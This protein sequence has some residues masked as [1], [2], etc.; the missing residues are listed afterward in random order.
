LAQGS[1]GTAR[2]APAARR[3]CRGGPMRLTVATFIAVGALPTAPPRESMQMQPS[4]GCAS[5]FHT[6]APVLFPLVPAVLPRT[7]GL[8]HQ[9]YDQPACC[10]PAYTL[11]VQA[12]VEGALQ[13]TAQWPEDRRHCVDRMLEFYTGAACSLCDPDWTRYSTQQPGG[14]WVVTVREE[15]CHYLWAACSKVL[16]PTM[17]SPQFC[18]ALANLHDG[19]VEQILV[20]TEPVTTTAE[21]PVSVVATVRHAKQRLRHVRPASNGVAALQL[22]VRHAHA[23]VLRN[24]ATP[25]SNSTAEDDEEDDDDEDNGD[26]LSSAAED[27]LSKEVDAEVSDTDLKAAPSATSADAPSATS[28]DAP[29]DAVNTTASAAEPAASSDA[30]KAKD[31]SEAPESGTE[32]PEGVPQAQ[33]GIAV[34]HSKEPGDDEDNATVVNI[35]APVVSSAATDATAQAAGAPCKLPFPA[36]VFSPLP[37]ALSAVDEGQFGGFRRGPEA[38]GAGPLALALGALLALS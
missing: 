19:A 10:L 31:A 13:R 2:G 20:H 12:Q 9:F 22:S 32:A 38:G 4:A 24:N 33:T 15:N 28:A 29:S 17:T 1:E 5:P 7:A 23:S 6:S 18:G 26:D 3:A 16:E 25:A 11:A 35:S 14:A 8:C 21:P 37:H 36:L 30:P 27:V 34:V